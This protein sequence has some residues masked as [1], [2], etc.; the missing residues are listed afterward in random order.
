MVNR[1]TKLCNHRKE[2]EQKYLASRERV[3]RENQE[4]LE[5]WE[6]RIGEWRERV[7]TLDRRKTTEV[8]RVSSQFIQLT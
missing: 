1:S 4:K 6:R 7:D 2:R 3:E 8:E 5:D